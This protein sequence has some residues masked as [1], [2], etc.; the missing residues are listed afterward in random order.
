[1]CTVL[2]Q[3][4]F[5]SYFLFSSVPSPCFFFYFTGFLVALRALEMGFPVL[6]DIFRRGFT[7]YCYLGLE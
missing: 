2:V 1:M 5:S 3:M 4:G 7:I 6:K